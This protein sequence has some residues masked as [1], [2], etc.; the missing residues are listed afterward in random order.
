MAKILCRPVIEI[1]TTRLV[2]SFFFFQSIALDSREIWICNVPHSIFEILNEVF[3]NI[4]FL[5][6]FLTWRNVRSFPR[7]T[8]LRIIIFG[9]PEVVCF[10]QA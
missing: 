4:V 6:C 8:G 9:P 3:D 1:L 2:W 7:H 5:F 10:L